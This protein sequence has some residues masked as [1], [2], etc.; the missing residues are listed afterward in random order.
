MTRPIPFNRRWTIPEAAVMLLGWFDQVNAA[1][2][3]ASQVLL[4]NALHGNDRR[5]IEL[6]DNILEAIR[7]TELTLST[8]DADFGTLA[9]FDVIDWAIN[10][11]MDDISP[12][13]LNWHEWYEITTDN[14]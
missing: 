1:P 5:G 2:D 7:F 11:G 3:S 4:A 13:C 6:R 14:P 10:W 12:E 9:P 8:D